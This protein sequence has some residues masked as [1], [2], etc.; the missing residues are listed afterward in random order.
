MYGSGGAAGRRMTPFGARQVGA[1]GTKRLA[2]TGM[3]DA[4]A[5]KK[6]VSRNGIGVK[7]EKEKVT[8][9]ERKQHLIVGI[10]TEGSTISADGSEF[11]INL[12]KFPLHVPPNAF[13]VGIRLVD[14][15]VPYVW[16]NYN[17]SNDE[18]LT[19]SFQDERDYVITEVGE[20]AAGYAVPS[21]SSDNIK[22]SANNYYVFDGAASAISGYGTFDQDFTEGAGNL[23]GQD[24]GEAALTISDASSDFTISGLEDFVIHLVW[25]E[26]SASQGQNLVDEVLFTCYFF[27]IYRTV[28][29][30]S[31]FQE[32]YI[33]FSLDGGSTFQAG[34][35]MSTRYKINESNVVTVL[36]V[37]DEVDTTVVSVLYNDEAIL[38]D[39][40]LTGISNPT[41]TQGHKWQATTGM[42]YADKFLV[43]F[44]NIAKGAIFNMGSTDTL[45]L[46][47]VT[48]DTAGAYSFWY[49]HGILLNEFKEFEL[50]PHIK[51]S[52]AGLTSNSSLAA[53]G[54]LKIPVL[55][56]DDTSLSFV[57]IPT[58]LG[59]M[60]KVLN[61]Y[62]FRE[63]YMSQFMSV[64]LLE[65]T[66]G[67]SGT[68]YLVQF[69]YDL[70]RAQS[71]SVL[72]TAF[73]MN[74]SL[75]KTGGNK[76]TAALEPCPYY[77]YEYGGSHATLLTISITKG[78]DP[79]V[80]YN[81]DI[82]D[83]DDQ[84]LN[85]THGDDAT[86]DLHIVLSRD[87]VAKFVYESIRRVLIDQ[88]I[89][90]P[91]PWS[92]R[93]SQPSDSCF[94]Y[95][96]DNTATRTL[97]LEPVVQHT[98][99]GEVTS[100]TSITLDSSAGVQVGDSV[101]GTN[102][103]SGTTVT[104]VN[105]NGT[106]ITLSTAVT[107][108]VSDGATLSF[109]GS[110]RNI[111]SFTFKFKP[112]DEWL[113]DGGDIIHG[114]SHQIN[115]FTINTSG[116]TNQVTQTIGATD[117]VYG[118]YTKG[119]EAFPAAAHEVGAAG[120]TGLLFNVFKA[121]DVLTMHITVEDGLYNLEYINSYLE[122][123]VNDFVQSHKHGASGDTSL[124][125][126]RGD[127]FNQQ[128]QIGALLSIEDPA[129]PSNVTFTFPE[130]TFNAVTGITLSTN[131]IAGATDGTYFID[132]LS[133]SG[134]GSNFQCEVTVASGAVTA[135]GIVYGGDSFAASETISITTSD[136][137]V[138]ATGSLVLTVSSVSPQSYNGVAQMLFSGTKRS[139][140][141]ANDGTNY[142]TNGIAVTTT[143]SATAYAYCDFQGDALTS[144]V[145]KPS[146]DDENSQY[147]TLDYSR[148]ISNFAGIRHV[149]DPK[150]ETTR[151]FTFDPFS[152]VSG[153]VDKNLETNSYTITIPSGSYNAE[154]LT[155]MIDYL[156]RQA[157]PD[158]IP[159][160]VQVREL[161]SIQKLQLGCFLSSDPN[162]AYP[163]SVTF[164]ATTPTKFA[165]LIGWNLTD[166]DITI[167][168]P[169]YR[170]TNT[171]VAPVYNTYFTNQ[172]NFETR[173]VF[174][175]SNFSRNATSPNGDP[176]QIVVAFAP[177]VKRGENIIINPN[178]PIINDAGTY[179][180]DD[181]LDE[182]RFKL[183]D[184]VT[185]EALAIGTADNNA[186]TVVL[187]LEYDEAKDQGEIMRPADQVNLATGV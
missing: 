67:S 149:L 22:A 126:V 143:G 59:Y 166:G 173:S 122:R 132:N 107:D 172:H 24:L 12:T 83:M 90:A 61:Q 119:S 86:I 2:S 9:V 35:R 56:E 181:K 142:S 76:F 62:I 17:N 38:I 95:I 101:S 37:S 129:L 15:V 60:Q 102:I 51:L 43:G 63:F 65:N 14:L 148:V 72:P 49:Q 4:V 154:T 157:N 81:F 44:V 20:N 10:S 174:L 96:A 70:R 18:T 177:R 58:L 112:F 31:G 158:I 116:L 91:P 6:A 7:K 103:A 52:V 118:I 123:K 163:H 141:D 108:T 16:P 21:V 54:V 42:N 176:L 1:R 168:A 164:S 137:G 121:I 185:K 183:V 47:Y 68:N 11:S 156:L 69:D 34:T 135:V 114:T 19:I 140:G 39:S 32:L 94:E 134:S 25:E 171:T 162:N 159:N 160:L 66:G 88:G 3:T 136:L 64:D 178:Q 98:V 99:D 147:I 33:R 152:D 144:L 5:V 23:Q 46:G 180:K 78:T 187:A 167:T 53:G 80:V 111:E 30:E 93:A 113:S 153:E 110:N 45:S 79:A 131:T 170:E 186:Y 127:E 138:S 27:E 26:E 36:G 57:T 145:A 28:N 155:E 125:K 104:A 175:L 150:D 74:S 139:M 161:K 182:I 29:V 117:E 13:N 109:E 179:L 169:D 84:V 184:G 71:V 151:I 50:K 115:S 8:A 100:G 40:S 77:W 41:P 75:Y 130:Q 73:T 55:H 82:T 133:G 128:A 105:A 165:S 92:N 87:D 124:F 106:D 97:G 89:Y 120:D 146:Y 48:D 85:P